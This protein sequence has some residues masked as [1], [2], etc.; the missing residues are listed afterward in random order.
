MKVGSFH[1]VTVSDDLIRT[2]QENGTE[3][4]MVHKL[5]ENTKYL[6]LNATKEGMCLLIYTHKTLANRLLPESLIQLDTTFPYTQEGI[7]GHMQT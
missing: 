4:K 1:I 6:K 5:R 3:I 7:S 2:Q